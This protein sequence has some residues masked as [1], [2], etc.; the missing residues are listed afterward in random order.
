MKYLDY[1][2]L[3]Y[4]NQLINSEISARPKSTDIKA[5]AGSNINK[6]GVPTVAFSSANNTFSVTIPSDSADVIELIV[7]DTSSKNKSLV[8]I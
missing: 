3:T 1:E 6:V 5:A 2:G 7:V 4:F 8:I